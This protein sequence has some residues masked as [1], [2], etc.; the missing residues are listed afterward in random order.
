MTEGILPVAPDHNSL[1]KGA[2]IIGLIGLVLSFVPIIGFVSWILGPLAVL[3]GLVALRK[4]PRSLAI[5]G[6]ITG[7]LAI[8]ICFWWISATKSIG[9][10]M[11]KD[12]FNTS[13]E[14]ID[15]S[16]SPILDTTIK[17]VWAD[18]ENNK[19]AAGTKYGGHRLRF[20]NEIIED[21]Q[22]DAETPA[23]S[24]VGKNEE[25]ISH[26]VSA[27]FDSADGP[28]IGE[29]KKGGKA[30]FVCNSVKETFGDG[31]SLGGCKLL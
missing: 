13:G 1:G 8:M 12:A 27:S 21:F 10:A 28:K 20:T 5:A 14:V 15:L 4:P 31:Y 6:I 23:M 18:I 19:V 11:N 7:G 2:F 16:N 9:E 24:F 26:M 17:G 25:Y 3:L 29:L 30:S 22:G